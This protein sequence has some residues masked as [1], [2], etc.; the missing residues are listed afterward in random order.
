MFLTLL[1]S[2]IYDF[3]PLPD[4]DVGSPVLV[5]DVEHTSLWSV[6]AQH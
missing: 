3:C 6:V 2:F 4:P 1:I 5:Y